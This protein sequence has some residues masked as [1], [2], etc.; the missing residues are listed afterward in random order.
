M[1][2]ESVPAFPKLLVHQAVNIM[3][4][5]CF[6]GFQELIGS[7]K[8]ARPLFDRE[9]ADIFQPYPPDAFQFGV[10]HERRGYLTQSRSRGVLCSELGHTCAPVHLQREV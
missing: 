7:M 6:E 2:K 9:R 8:K 10:L 3:K 4:M 1:P 5:D